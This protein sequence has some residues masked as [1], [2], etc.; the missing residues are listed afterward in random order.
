MGEDRANEWRQARSP[1]ALVL[2]LVEK[3]IHDERLLA[4]F[5]QIRRADFVPIAFV[6]EAYRDEPVS[7][8]HQQVTTQP[9]L[10]ALMVQALRLTGT[11]KVLEI[12]TGFGFQTAILSRLCHQ[13]FSI[14]RMADLAMTAESNLRKAGIQNAKVVVGDGT[15][16]LPDHAPFEA[17]VVSAAAPNVPQP[18]VDQLKDGGRLVQ[19]IGPGG[20][21]T[22]MSFQKIEGSLIKKEEI[23]RA[24]FVPLLGAFGVRKL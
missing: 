19:P 13:V 8:G 22:V 7:I 10:I 23:T 16:G 3:G 18:V 17:I 24:Y 2:G 9:S 20:E 15:L 5:A 14:E 1:A 6:S 21:E 12:G 11:E 4:A